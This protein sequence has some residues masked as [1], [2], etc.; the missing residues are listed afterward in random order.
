[1]NE[2]V[3]PSLSTQETHDISWLTES[4]LCHEFSSLASAQD[5]SACHRSRDYPSCARYHE[6]P[7]VW[8][9]SCLLF[10]PFRAI[11]RHDAAFNRGAEYFLLEEKPLPE[12][13]VIH[14]WNEAFVSFRERHV[15]VLANIHTYRRV[16]VC[17]YRTGVTHSLW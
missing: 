4:R 14:C 17:T 1:M 15:Y 8:R 2:A 5:S 16:P 3:M 13:R 11:L 6:R 12:I 10:V 9:D 7:G